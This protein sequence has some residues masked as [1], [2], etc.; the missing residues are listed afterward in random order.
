M[1]PPM[2]MTMVL[3]A[4]RELSCNCC[5]CHGALANCCAL[6]RPQ[7]DERDD[8]FVAVERYYDQL[9]ICRHGQRK[10]VN[11][12]EFPASIGEIDEK[13]SVNTNYMRGSW[14]RHA[15]TKKGAMAACGVRGPLA[16][17]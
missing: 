4:Q 12:S 11:H 6:N 1:P 7:L 15:A 5:T 10:Y 8:A 3:S 9:H 17:R 14:D 2:T 16:Y 13:V